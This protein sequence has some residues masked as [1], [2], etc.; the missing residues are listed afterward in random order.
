[1]EL[2][3]EELNAKLT[4]G[5][6]LLERWILLESWTLEILAKAEK[7]STTIDRIWDEENI[8]KGDFDLCATESIAYIRSLES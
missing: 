8:K 5:V 6:L 4:E 3:N 2:T 7:A 1:M